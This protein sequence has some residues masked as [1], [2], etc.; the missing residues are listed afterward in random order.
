MPFNS[1]KFSILWDFKMRNVI[2]WLWSI[3][4]LV[5]TWRRNGVDATSLRRIDVSTTSCAIWEFGPLAPPP[6]P[7]PPQYSKHW[8]PQYSK[9]SYAYAY[10]C[11]A[12][13]LYCQL[14]THFSLRTDFWK[15]QRDRA[16][17]PSKALTSVNA[18]KTLFDCYYCINSS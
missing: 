17:V 4:N 2:G 16:N 18:M 12:I 5:A 1:I 13:L 9:P 10:C 15:P 14:Y 8:P 6:P 7:P 11:T 3:K